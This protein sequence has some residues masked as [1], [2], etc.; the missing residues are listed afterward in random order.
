QQY[1]SKLLSNDSLNK[2]NMQYK[3]ME[4]ESKTY[5]NDVEKNKRKLEKLKDE[6]NKLNDEKNKTSELLEKSMLQAQELDEEDK[7]NIKEQK[8]D[9]EENTKGLKIGDQDLERVLNFYGDMDKP[10]NEKKIN[11]QEININQRD[12]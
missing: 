11:N 7:E 12:W 3:N 8:E 5:G 1:N 6:E 2:A 10:N 4:K 9:K